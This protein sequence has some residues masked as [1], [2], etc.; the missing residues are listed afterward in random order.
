MRLPGDAI[1]LFISA[2]QA[3]TGAST[4]I[5]F[6]ITSYIDTKRKTNRN[7]QYIQRSIIQ[8]LHKNLLGDFLYQY[9]N[10]YNRDYHQVTSKIHTKPHTYEKV[11][12]RLPFLRYSG[13]VYA[14]FVL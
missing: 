12:E 4:F 6:F 9:L 1:G 10:I 2:P 14:R 8:P 13:G 11:V 5:F 3:D 7:L